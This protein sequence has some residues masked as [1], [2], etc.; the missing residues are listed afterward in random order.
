MVRFILRGS[1]RIGV[2]PTMLVMLCI[3]APALALGACATTKT[4]PTSQTSA[5]LPVEQLGIQAD[6]T[7][8]NIEGLLNFVLDEK[9]H[10]KPR[11]PKTP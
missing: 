4:A 3:L 5:Q 1:G 6:Q 2:I 11:P 10:K 8:N 7:S 9:A